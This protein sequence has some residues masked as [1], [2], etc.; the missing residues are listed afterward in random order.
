MVLIKTNF[1]K[2]FE[3]NCSCFNLSIDPV[4]ERGYEFSNEALVNVYMKTEYDKKSFVSQL[5]KEIEK[6]FKDNG[7]DQSFSLVKIQEAGEWSFSN[8]TSRRL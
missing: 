1:D 7:F 3:K 6:I 4:Y 8:K 5:K 2:V